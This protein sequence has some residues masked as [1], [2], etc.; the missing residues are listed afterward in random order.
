MSFFAD[1]VTLQNAYIVGWL[2]TTF[3]FFFF[4][5]WL[6][7]GGADGDILHT[8][9]YVMMARKWPFSKCIN[10]KFTKSQHTNCF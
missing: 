4:F 8:T 5:F 9:N 10:T 6:G 2:H 7:T 3:F 1:E